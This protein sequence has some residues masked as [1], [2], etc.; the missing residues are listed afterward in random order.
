MLLTILKFVGALFLGGV[1]VILIMLGVEIMRIPNNE[2]ERR[3]SQTQYQMNKNKLYFKERLWEEV[4]RV[5][6]KKWEK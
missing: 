4:E 3:R 2:W 1:G 6:Y 5:E